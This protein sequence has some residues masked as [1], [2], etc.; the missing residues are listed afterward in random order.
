MNNRIF[1]GNSPAWEHKG[2]ERF[3]NVSAIAFESGFPFPTYI[4]R[5]FL[6]TYTLAGSGDDEGELFVAVL[7]TEV[8]A[9]LN[10]VHPTR[11]VSY[12]HS[13]SM[14]FETVAQHR[15]RPMPDIVTVK[16]FFGPWHDPVVHILVPE[17]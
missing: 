8:D 13:F 14:E 2:L 16:V 11:N 7:L 3:A 15:R 4:C 9:A 5:K 1:D 17:L 6:A 10:A 12:G